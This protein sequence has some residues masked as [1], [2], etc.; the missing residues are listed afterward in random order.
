MEDE[1]VIEEFDTVAVRKTSI[2]ST[3]SNKRK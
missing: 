2:L 3:N 1:W